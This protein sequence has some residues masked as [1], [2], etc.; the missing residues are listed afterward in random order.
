MP[1]SI[2]PL[3]PDAPD[4]VWR[5][6]AEYIERSRLRRFMREAGVDS[7]G[8]LLAW[9]NADPARFWDAAVRDLDLSSISRIRAR[10]T[11]RAACPGRVGSP[12]ASTTTPTTPSI[13]GPMALARI[14]RPWCGRVKRARRAR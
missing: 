4:I 6:T 3:N 1:S 5:P 12:A 9:S 8:A 14:R 11:S 13:S 7:Y 10:L 2:P